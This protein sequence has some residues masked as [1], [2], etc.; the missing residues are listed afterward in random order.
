MYK[1]KKEKHCEGCPSNTSA[2]PN[3]QSV[4]VWKDVSD[5]PPGR[6]RVISIVQK[7][8]HNN[9]HPWCG[10]DRHFRLVVVRAAVRAVMEIMHG[11]E[12]KYHDSENQP[13]NFR[14]CKGR[15]EGS[16]DLP[17]SPATWGASLDYLAAVTARAEAAGEAAKRKYPVVILKPLKEI[18]NE[19]QTEKRLGIHDEPGPVA[20]EPVPP[21]EAA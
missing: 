8:M 14:R 19:Y 18:S 11:N 12:V 21:A 16:P 1:E 13:A 9:P 3:N 15:Q 2:D 5:Y 10:F 6:R 7:L 17:S 4:C 20:A